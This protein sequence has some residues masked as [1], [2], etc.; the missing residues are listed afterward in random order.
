MPK[1]MKAAALLLSLALLALLVVS[2]GITGERPTPPEPAPLKE[3][4]TETSPA[5][6]ETYAGGVLLVVAQKDFQDI[7]YNTVRDELAAAGY[8]V[9]VAAPQKAAASGV[10]GTRVDPDLSL[11]EARA[12]A[13]LAVIFIGGPGTEDLFDLPDAHRIATE[14]VGQGKPLAAI[15]LA[16][17]IL[18]RAGVLAGKR[19]TV[20]PS[21]SG[22]LKAGGATYTGADVE[23]DGKIITASGPE[24]SHDFARAIIDALR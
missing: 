20:Y 9:S 14:T 13:Y 5:A 17:A 6:Q 16:P 7:E 24:A 3:N 8:R 4:G 15:C 19:A 23:I 21:V 2:C 11:S 1:A 12:S 22:D 10:S 18:A